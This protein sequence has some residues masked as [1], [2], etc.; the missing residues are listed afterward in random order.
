MRD[1]TVIEVILIT[2]LIGFAMYGMDP[3]SKRLGC[4]GW[5][6]YRRVK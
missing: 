3:R 2:M 5:G 4:E 1:V 6:E